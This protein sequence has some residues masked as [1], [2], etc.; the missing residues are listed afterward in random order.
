MDNFNDIEFSNYRYNEE[1]E[2]LSR[3]RN[4]LP[5]PR[6]RSPRPAEKPKKKK[7]SGFL[8]R[9]K[10]NFKDKNGFDLEELRK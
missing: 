2:N 8:K 9:L 3:M 4:T 7:I 1:Q 5:P 10:Q 6:T